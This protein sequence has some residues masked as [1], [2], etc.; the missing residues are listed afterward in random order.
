M[1]LERGAEVNAQA[2]V[3]L[4]RFGCSAKTTPPLY[5][6]HR[7]ANGPSVSYIYQKYPLAHGS[8][9]VGWGLFHPAV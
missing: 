3:S 7:P 6:D 1:L 9:D 8:R 2:Q 4:A 5:T